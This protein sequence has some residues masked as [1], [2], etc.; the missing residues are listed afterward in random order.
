MLTRNLDEVVLASVCETRLGLLVSV[1][2]SREPSTKLIG[3]YSAPWW[4]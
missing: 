3:L 4:R 2:R 1:Q